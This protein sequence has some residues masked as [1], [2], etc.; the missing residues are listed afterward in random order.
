MCNPAAKTPLMDALERHQGRSAASLHT[1][2]HKGTA[3][4][5]SRL[6]GIRY[7]LTELPDTGSL[8]DGGD[9]IEES[10]KLAAAAFGA[11]M[12]LYSGGGCTLCIQTML[13]L[14]RNLAGDRVLMGRNAHRSAVHAAALLGLTVE[15]LWPDGGLGDQPTVENID[16]KL[17]TFPD[18]RVVYLTSP[19]YTG[20]MADIAGAAAVCRRHGALLLVDNAHG[21]H[22]GAFGR[23]PLALGADMCADSAHK[24]L[25][26]LTGGAMLQLSGRL[27]GGET[28]LVTRP[29]AKA[30][31]ALFASTSP[32]FPVLAS[33]DLAQNWW[34]GEG[35]EAYREIACRVA[36]F[37]RAARESGILAP[38]GEGMDPA[39][40][41]L[42]VT[43]LG[44]TGLQAAAFF[45]EQGLEP[46]HADDRWV[47][48][49]VT[50]FLTR[51][52]LARLARA[53]R[54]LPAWAAGQ[55]KR[56]A[57]VC[58]DP[59]AVPRPVKRMEPRQAMLR[60]AE[61]VSAPVAAGRVAARSVCPCPP[62]IAAVAPGEEI[63]RELA[64]LLPQWGYSTVQVVKD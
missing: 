63:S 23:H 54:E 1:P 50:P 56:E 34:R 30:A 2:G 7:D 32:P 10:E 45:R 64:R 36:G 31:M 16:E 22:L 58:F 8:F 49:I 3:P 41:A 52:Q 33:L 24:T 44:I 46:E 13:L 6:G 18:I 21:S 53:V 57:A 43:A 25:P 9:C 60:E 61:E 47:I 4:V 5:L 59:F 20:R 42:D 48:G 29:A 35:P 26:V 62:G 14:A 51:K 27:T 55:E 38:D 17:K 40:L 39:R 12:T 19:D 37:R 15:W 28:P 11:G